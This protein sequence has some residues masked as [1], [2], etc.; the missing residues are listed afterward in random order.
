MLLWILLK[1][2]DIFQTWVKPDKHNGHFAWGHR[3]FYAPI[4]SSAR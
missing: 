1:F 2:N 3:R 4:L